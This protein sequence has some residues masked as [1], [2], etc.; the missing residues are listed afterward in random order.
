[1]KDENEEG[2]ISLFATPYLRLITIC[3]L[4]IWFTMNLVYY[5]LMLNMN[6]FGGNVYFNLVSRAIENAFVSA[7]EGV[8]LRYRLHS[9]KTITQTMQ[10]EEGRNE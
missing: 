3:F 5:G 6:K 9:F 7:S 4:C 1:M 10:M 2:Y 8:W